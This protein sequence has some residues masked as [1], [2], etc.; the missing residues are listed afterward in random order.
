MDHADH[1][2][3]MDLGLETSVLENLQQ[4]PVMP[5]LIINNNK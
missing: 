3:S 2:Q 1:L 5:L 4:V